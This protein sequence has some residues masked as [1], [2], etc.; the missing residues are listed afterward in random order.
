MVQPRRGLLGPSRRLCLI[1]CV[2]A[3]LSY[4]AALSVIISLSRFQEALIP[5]DRRESPS[6]EA[7]R[8]ASRPHL[9]LRGI[10]LPRAQSAAAAW[11]ETQ[12]VGGASDAQ[13]RTCKNITQLTTSSRDASR[14]LFF[15]FIFLFFISFSRCLGS[16][17]SLVVKTPGS[18]S[19]GQ[20]EENEVTRSHWSP[21]AAV[22]ESRAGSSYGMLS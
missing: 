21:S 4:A 12:A 20:G 17:F 3:G 2:P 10:S 11:R 6:P 22:L 9:P 13:R 19:K 7:Q 5:S 15:L 14:R 18:I 1:K 8:H 16:A